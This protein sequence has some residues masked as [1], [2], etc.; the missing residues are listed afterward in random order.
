VI[1]R[2]KGRLEAEIDALVRRKEE[3]WRRFGQCGYRPRFQS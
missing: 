3:P 2:L 1:E